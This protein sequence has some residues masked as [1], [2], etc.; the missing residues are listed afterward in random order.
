MSADIHGLL[1]AAGH[2]AHSIHPADLK[3][4]DIMIGR[5]AEPVTALATSAILNALERGHLSLDEVEGIFGED[6]LA[7]VY[8]STAHAGIAGDAEQGDARKGPGPEDGLDEERE[9]VPRAGEDGGVQAAETA[10]AAGAEDDESGEAP[11]GGSGTG[12]DS[13]AAE[14]RGRLQAVAE[15]LSAIAAELGAIAADIVPA[16]A[17]EAE[18]EADGSRSAPVIVESAD[19]IARAGERV[20]AS[21]SVGQREA[22][23][24]KMGHV[25]FDGLDLTIETPKGATRR[26]IGADG[27]EWQSISPAAY[28][29]A[30]ATQGADGDHVDIYLADTAKPGQ[31]FIVDQIDPQTRAFDEHKVVL[32]AATKNEARAIFVKGF[33][34]GSGPRRIGAV[35]GMSIE[36]FKDWLRDGDQ[37]KP[38]AAR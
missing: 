35:T 5:G 15:R 26:G 30:K 29:Y 23:N 37:T 18:P 24:Y 38:F 3:R 4:A 28:G 34:D 16:P 17:E 6:A 36:T 13:D 10:G 21:P 22:G 14:D 2:S 27:K 11:E 33:S 1:R 20:H 31:A 32:G 7:N 8:G 12:G 25:V 9:H 19:D